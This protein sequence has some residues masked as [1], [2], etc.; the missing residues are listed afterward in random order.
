[1]YIYI[2]VLKYIS[3]DTL[4]VLIDLFAPSVDVS[5]ISISG[6]TAPFGRG[7]IRGRKTGCYLFHCIQIHNMYHIYIV[8]HIQIS[9]SKHKSYVWFY[10]SSIYHPHPPIQRIDT[11]FGAFRNGWGP[12]TSDWLTC[13]RRSP[14]VPSARSMAT[15]AWACARISWSLKKNGGS[16]KWWIFWK[17]LVLTV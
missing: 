1:M 2:Y 13:G 3:I 12:W 8:K 15:A 7:P 11:F 16:S 9:I 5:Y 4:F 14:K 17:F 10:I 6:V